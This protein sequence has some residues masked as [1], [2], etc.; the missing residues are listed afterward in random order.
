MESEIL[1][2]HVKKGK[3]G[4]KITNKK[5]VYMGNIM[6][7]NFKIGG[8]ELDINYTKNNPI[9]GHLTM[10][11]YSPKCAVGANLRGTRIMLNALFEH[12]HDIFPGI[13]Q[14]F[15]EDMSKIDCADRSK[16]RNR[17]LVKPIDLARFSIAFNG[18][19]WYEKY[20]GARLSDNIQQESYRDAVNS[21]LNH[22]PSLQELNIPSEI[23]EEILKYYTA[24]ITLSELL[25]RIPHV[26]R[27]KHARAWIIKYVVKILGGK[28]N[29][30]G[31]AID[32][33][34][35]SMRVTNK[36]YCPNGFRRT[37]FTRRE[38]VETPEYV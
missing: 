31:W 8:I 23:F 28:F 13:K 25:N 37:N 11:E 10:V 5:N 16:S 19:T 26:D 22:T 33:P 15:F 35:M 6:S 9:S 18:T 7:H 20:F 2:T 29:H 36:Y 17:S 12:I 32:L 38:C 4:F 3:H 1:V 24:T 14:I 34:V 30:D 21:M 27:C